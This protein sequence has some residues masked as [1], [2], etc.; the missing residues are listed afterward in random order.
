MTFHSGNQPSIR[1]CIFNG[2]EINYN[3]LKKPYSF[4]SITTKLGKYC[5]AFDNDNEYWVSDYKNIDLNLTIKDK[6]TLEYMR[7]LT[8]EYVI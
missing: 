7:D 3:P 1:S 6:S 8:I 5:I 4:Y 2:L